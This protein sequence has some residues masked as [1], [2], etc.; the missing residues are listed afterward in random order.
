MQMQ[1]D[2]FL[3]KP[4]FGPRPDLKSAPFC[5]P[6]IKIHSER[7]IHVTCVEMMQKIFH[8]N[9]LLTSRLQLVSLDICEQLNSYIFIS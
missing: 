7:L 3:R 5:L 6:A 1:V 8:Q 4:I 2:V 9:H